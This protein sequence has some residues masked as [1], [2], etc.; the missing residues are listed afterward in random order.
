[1]TQH[2]LAVALDIHPITIA[3]HEKKKN[4]RPVPRE[5]LLAVCAIAMWAAFR[6]LSADSSGV[7]RARHAPAARVQR[8]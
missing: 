7:L 3:N 1:M 2:Q 5:R 8:R 6:E 4:P